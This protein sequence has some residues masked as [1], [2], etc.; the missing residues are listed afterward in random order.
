MNNWE[1][2]GLVEYGTDG[3]ILPSLAS[4]WTV[5]DEGNGQKYTF[6][7]RQGVQFHDG[8]SWNCTV[9]KLNFDHVLAEELT[10]GDWHGWYGLPAQLTNWTCPSEFV[11][12]LTTSG[13][14]YPLANF[15]FVRCV[16]FHLLSSWEVSPV[17]LTLRTRVRPAGV[18]FPERPDVRT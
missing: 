13:K 12:E 14:Y 11:L 15:L 16:C 10:T 1:Y 7:L 8:E 18:T 9:A 4:S 17:I 6:N 5:E 3:T 2:E